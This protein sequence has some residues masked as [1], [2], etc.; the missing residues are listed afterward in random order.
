MKP[1]VRVLL[2]TLIFVLLTLPAVAPA[3]AAGPPNLIQIDSQVAV[4]N[5]GSLGITYRLTFR[6]TDSRN[7]ISSLG[8]LDS[9]HSIRSA[10]I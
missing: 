7:Q 9:G 3:F 5:D 6:E 1:L 2:V 8:P 4:K 10:E